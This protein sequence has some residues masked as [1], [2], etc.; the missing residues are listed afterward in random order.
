LLNNFAVEIPNVPLIKQEVQWCGPAA[1]AS[2]MSYWGDSIDQETIAASV[3]SAGLKGSLITDLKGYAEKRG[4]QTSLS[5]G[6]LEELKGLI[7]AKKPVIVLVDR[8]FWI[9]SR[10]H[11]MVVV[12]YDQNGLIVHA[13]GEKKEAIAYSDFERMWKK[14]GSTCLVIFK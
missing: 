13:G 14:M 11:Y 4:Y 8:G 12:G 10:P 2:V 1:L 6:M 3:H 7:N 5:K 9:I